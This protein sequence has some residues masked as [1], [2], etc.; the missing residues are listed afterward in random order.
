MRSAESRLGAVESL[1]SAMRGVGRT[2][3]LVSVPSKAMRWGAMAGGALLGL[4]MVRWFIRSRKHSSVVPLA[5]VPRGGLSSSLAQVLVQVLPIVLAPWFRSQV[6]SGS[7]GKLL[8]CLN[9]GH[10][11][12]RWLGFEK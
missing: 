5:P 6:L 2:W 10:L 11:L 4:G 3:E 9:P 8:S 7:G 1:D 12:S